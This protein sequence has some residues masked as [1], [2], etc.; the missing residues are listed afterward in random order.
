[1]RLTKQ[2]ETKFRE[3]QNKLSDGLAFTMTKVS[4]IHDAK[5]Q[6]IHAPSKRL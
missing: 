3:I 6:Y 5:K 4:I 2:N 1:M